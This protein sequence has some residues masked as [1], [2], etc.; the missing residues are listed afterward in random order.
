MARTIRADGDTWTARLSERPP[1]PG[2][3]TIVFFCETTGQRPYRVIDVPD[4][5]L[6]SAGVLDAVPQDELERLFRESGSL[7]SPPPRV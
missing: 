7:A 4:E 3:Q 1:R 5:R 6:G 2:F